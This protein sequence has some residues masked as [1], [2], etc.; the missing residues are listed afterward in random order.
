MSCM[1][2]GAAQ[3]QSDLSK[4]DTGRVVNMNGMFRNAGRFDSNIFEWNTARCIYK[5]EMLVNSG[6]H[7]TWGIKDGCISST[8]PYHK[9]GRIYAFSQLP[10]SISIKY[11][12]SAYL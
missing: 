3:F 5:S 7:R 9:W 11:S 2:Y 6:L 12:I 10:Q 4:W 1:F 8:H